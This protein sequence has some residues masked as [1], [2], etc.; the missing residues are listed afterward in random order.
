MTTPASSA[1][2]AVPAEPAAA[3]GVRQTLL[4]LGA[5]GDLTGRLLLPGLGRLLAT[6]AVPGLRL[7]GSGMD[8]W[9]DERWRRR[10][11]DSFGTVGAVGPV[12][13]EVIQ[14]TR[15][16]PA[17]VTREEDL[18]SLLG[19]CTGP[20]VIFFALPP[21]VTARSAAAL[22]RI[23][24]PPGTRLML[25]KPFGVDRISARSLNELLATLVPE[26]QVHRIDHFLGKSTVLN[27]LGLRFANRI[28]EPVLNSS[29]VACVDIVFDE[30]LGLEGRAGYYD[31]AGALVDMV[32]SHLLQV[33]ALLA[34]D[35]PPTLRAEELRG[36]QAQVLRATRL[37]HDD[38]AV[39]SR[40]GRY[41][42][43]EIDGRRLPN[44]ADEPGV[45][46][47][48]GTETLAELAVTVDNWRWAGVPFRLRSGKA[49]DA[50]RKEA[51]I[52]FKQPT[53]VPDGLTGYERPDRL[54]IGFGPDRLGLDLNI[55]G[56]GNPFEL[57]QANLT[58][59]F[60]P[61]DLPAYGEVLRGAFDG[62]PTLSVRGDVAEECWRIVEPVLAAWKAGAVPLQEYRAGSA[63]PADSLIG[64]V[65]HVR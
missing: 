54:R 2:A 13:S 10:V 19:C 50:V 29:H 31:R 36:R 61:G 47:A 26:G 48:R 62:D 55:N 42:A 17:D 28:F 49:V 11:A 8:G 58:A 5:S 33:L 34:M 60:G 4:V 65:S 22:A 15:Y 35:P 41:T 56:P 57:E 16:V 38:P 23:G 27:L 7:I 46:P 1:P 52:T 3:T 63:G 32:Q 14:Q 64:P 39:A 53:R 30:T 6:G 9:D 40:R 43:G 51:I 45:D 59:D 24:V 12:E 44:Y 18:R 37:W 20:L 25:E 21:L